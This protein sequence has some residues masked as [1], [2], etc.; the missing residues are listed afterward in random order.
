MAAR[1]PRLWLPLTLLALPTTAI[2][3]G[4]ARVPP[5]GWASWNTH[6]AL[7][8]A[9]HI[10]RQADAMVSLGLVDLGYRYLE[11]DEPGFLRWPNG[12]LRTNLTRFPDGMAAVGDYLHARGLKF[13]MY[14]SAGPLTCAGSAAPPA[15]TH[16]RTRH[17]SRA[18]AS[19]RCWGDQRRT[20]PDSQ[21]W[22]M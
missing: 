11:I 10:M 1:P 4:V 12:T 22:W 13:G 8:N 16:D 20:P 5:L 6:G 7:V 14:S 9:S 21:W 2:D 18:T 15:Y 3:N 17:T 19:P